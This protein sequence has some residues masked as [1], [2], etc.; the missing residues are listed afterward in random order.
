MWK[1]NFAVY[2]RGADLAGRINA[3]FLYDNL[4]KEIQYWIYHNGLT[5][6]ADSL[7]TRYL[8]YEEPL[9]RLRTTHERVRQYQHQ[10]FEFRGIDENLRGIAE[11]RLESFERLVSEQLSWLIKEGWQGQLKRQKQKVQKRLAREGITVGHR[12]CLSDFLERAERV[13]GIEDFR[14]VEMS[15]KDEIDTCSKFQ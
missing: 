2:E 1:R 15:Y 8:Q 4:L 12:K 3:A 5:G 7:H 9:R 13:T 14:L 10:V 11:R 6:L